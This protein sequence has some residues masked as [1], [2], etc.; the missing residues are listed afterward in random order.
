MGDMTERQQLAA[1]EGWAANPGVPLTERLQAA[2]QVIAGLRNLR[3][4]D[5]LEFD[6]AAPDDDEQLMVEQ[7]IDATLQ[8]AVL[9][10]D[11]M[12]LH[13]SK[14]IAVTVPV[15]EAKRRYF[16]L[17]EPALW[18]AGVRLDW[19]AY[20]R[21]YVPHSLAEGFDPLDLIGYR[22]HASVGGAQG[23]WRVTPRA[24]RM[25][26]SLT[27]MEARAFAARLLAAADSC[28]E[29]NRQ[30]PGPPAPGSVDDPAHQEAARQWAA[31][32]LTEDLAKLDPPGE[33]TGP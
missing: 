27:A 17:A 3:P 1:L 10:R 23:G 19:S 13:Q 26:F 11:K 21:W 4:A 31:Q 16:E 7:V 30:M 20:Q 25:P 28:D 33:V 2:M 18:E 24:Q 29:H 14:R 6:G 32:T 22:Q 5:D 9:A 12:R 8:Y 15:D